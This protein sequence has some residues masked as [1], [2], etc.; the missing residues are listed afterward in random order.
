VS[1]RLPANRKRRAHQARI[2]VTIL[3]CHLET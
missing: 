1:F 2:I 3:R